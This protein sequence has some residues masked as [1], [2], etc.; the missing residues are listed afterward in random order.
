MPAVTATPDALREKL[1]RLEDLKRRAKALTGKGTPGPQQQIEGESAYLSNLRRNAEARREETKRGQDIYPIPE[2]KDWARRLACQSNLELFITTYLKSQFRLRFCDDHRKVMRKADQ[3]IMR[4]GLFAIAMPRKGGKTQITKAAALKAVLYGQRRFPLLIGATKQA[5][6]ELLDGIKYFFETT[7]EFPLLLAD[8]PEAIY[9]ILA[10][11]GSIRKQAGQH[12]RGLSTEL[13]WSK[14]VIDMPRVPD[15]NWI[16]GHTIGPSLSAGAKIRVTSIGGRVRGFNVNGDRPDFVIPDDCQTDQTAISEH[17]NEKIERILASAVIGLAAPDTKITGIMPCTCIAAGDCI[18]RILNHELH[19]EWDSE[20]TKGLYK[21]PSKMEVIEGQR[22]DVAMELWGKYRQIRNDYNP[23]L[24]EHEKAKAAEKATEFYIDNHEVMS[25]GAVVAW[26]ERCD[27]TE[28]DGLQC[29]MNLFYQDK[30][31]FAAEVQNDPLP[32]ELGDQVEMTALE[33]ASKVNKVPRFEV[34]I[35]L[36]KLTAFIDVQERLLYYCVCA[37]DDQFQGA[38]IDYGSFPDQRRPYFS[39]ADA[40]HTLSRLKGLENAGSQAQ[41]YGGL[42]QLTQLILG[43]T[44]IGGGV[45]HTVQRCLIDSGYETQLVYQFCRQSN[46]KNILTPSKGAGVTADQRS[47]TDHKRG[48]QEKPGLEWYALPPKE[49][50]GLRLLHFDSYFWKSLTMAQL[51]VP[52]GGKGI[53]LFGE[54]PLAHRMF[55]EQQLSEYRHRTKDDEKGRSGRIVDV[56]KLK[57]GAPDNHLWDAHVGCAVAAS[58]EG[59][60][61]PE[62]HEPA[63]IKPSGHGRKSWASM[64]QQKSRT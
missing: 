53:T 54:D 46:F 31:A 8:F 18:D 47:L 55:A 4:G 61:L 43:R 22:I 2:V 27:D 49:S 37:W 64:Q 38:V 13:D 35:G 59:V 42:D 12:T 6:F 5:A 7:H 45:S 56:W 21:F 62:V 41:I 14:T 32:I 58:Y 34:P 20:R 24:G 36:T 44:Y 60:A 26:P 33:I 9:P 39:Y 40:T 23:H 50:R 30:F 10:L 1:K 28:V 19:P 52:I 57:P 15:G 63:K 16:D 48:P 25:T 51:A 3:A 11:D 29:M 17:S